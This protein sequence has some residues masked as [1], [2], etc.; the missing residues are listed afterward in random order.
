M[1]DFNDIDIIED[2]YQ[3]SVLL[4]TSSYPGEPSNAEFKILHGNSP[5]STL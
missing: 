5:E 1:N 3:L 2:T 4:S